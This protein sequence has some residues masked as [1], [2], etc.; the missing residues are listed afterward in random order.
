[1]DTQDGPSRLEG[2]AVYLTSYIVGVIGLVASRADSVAPIWFAAGWMG[3]FFLPLALLGF[4]VMPLGTHRAWY[5]A[6]LAAALAVV[7]AVLSPTLGGPLGK[8]FEWSYA[9]GVLGLLA[10]SAVVR[11]AAARTK[12]SASRCGLQLRRNSSQRDGRTASSPK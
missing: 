10:V 1:M 12:A 9:A 3:A 5:F 2:F 6:R 4:V 11:V 8:T 7:L